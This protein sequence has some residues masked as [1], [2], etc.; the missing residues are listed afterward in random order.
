IWKNS[1]LFVFFLS[2]RIL[3]PVVTVL[4]FFVL[5]RWSGTFDTHALLIVTHATFHLP[6]VVLLMRQRFAEIPAAL[7]E[8]AA[9]EGCGPARYFGTIAL[10]IATPGLLAC[11]LIVMSFSWNEFL[12]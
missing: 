10:P 8:S 3:P 11:G 5:A 9:V 7:E 12:F 4:P 6:L 1:D 2:Q